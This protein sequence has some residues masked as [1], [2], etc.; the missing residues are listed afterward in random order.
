[1]NR[2]DKSDNF[3]HFREHLLENAGK[4]NLDNLRVHVLLYTKVKQAIFHCLTLP[5]IA[6][7]CLTL[8]LKSLA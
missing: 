1:M 7:H 8:P 4:S 2:G 6:L 3:M 5:Y